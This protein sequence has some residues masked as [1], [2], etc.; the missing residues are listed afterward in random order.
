MTLRQWSYRNIYLHSSYWSWLRGVVGRR[1]H[2]Q[3]E[4]GGCGAH[5]HNLNCHHTVYHLFREWLHISDMIYLCPHH[6]A[7]THGGWRLRLAH[8]R[9]LEPFVY[10][11]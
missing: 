8:G 10:R 7:Q 3:C 2:W 11:K 1:A 6:H 4:V 5:G 9:T